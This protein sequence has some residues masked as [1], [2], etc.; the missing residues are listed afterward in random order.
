MVDLE[1]EDNK[2]AHLLSDAIKHLLESPISLALIILSAVFIA[3]S[4][5]HGRYLDFGVFTL[6]YAVASGYWRLFAKDN[7]LGGDTIYHVINLALF[8][9]WVVSILKFPTLV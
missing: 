3:L 7:N 1:S 8:A 4:I 9:I 2:V 6:I 5:I